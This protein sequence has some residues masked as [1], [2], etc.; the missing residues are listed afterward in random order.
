MRD[1]I[2]SLHHLA[3]WSLVDPHKLQVLIL[4]DWPWAPI[5]AWKLFPYW[6]CF[7]T[8]FP[9]LLES[10]AKNLTSASTVHF[11][12]VILEI[13]HFNLHQLTISYSSQCLSGHKL[14][15]V[16]TWLQ[17]GAA[18]TSVQLQL[19]T[20]AFRQPKVAKPRLHSSTVA[21]GIASST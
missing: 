5:C 18:N 15:P 4:W 20:V 13:S 9:V 14:L 17:S 3:F 2:A 8:W 7:L 10:S 11:S 19:H 1:C 21:R 16:L 12:H 6:R